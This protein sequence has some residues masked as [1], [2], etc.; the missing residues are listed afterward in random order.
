MNRTILKLKKLSRPSI[1][2]LAL[3]IIILSV[4]FTLPL[5]TQKYATVLMST[6]FMYVVL[7][8]SWTIFSGTTRYISL[9]SAAFFGMGVYT[10]AVLGK[11]L[12]LPAIIGIG[13]LLSFCLALIIG[14]LTLRLKGIYFAMFTLGLVELIVTLLRWW[15]VKFSNT[16]GRLVVYTDYTIVYYVMLV[17][18]LLLILTVHL[19]RR[20]KYGM[21]LQ[22]IGECEEAAAHIGINTTLLKV[23]TFAV[24]ALFI[25]ATGV[26]MATRW[27]YVD[28]RI[29]F[30]LQFSFMPVM[31]AMIGGMGQLYGPII[32]AVFFTYLEEF[33]I[34]RLPYH[35]MLIFGA[36]LVAAILYLPE[37]L[38]GLA[39]KCW[40]RGSG[41]KHAHT[42]S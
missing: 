1:S 32:G 27:T 26:I 6:I 40:K 21:A 31:M 36:I 15:E 30:N 34:T 24:S 10:A 11:S 28:P 13:S 2:R 8:V 4:L 7:T 19:I 29:A 17:I 35:Y 42:S 18:L 14:A 20:S 37:G 5:Y 41:G 16:V 3:M 39:Q 22:S 23:V 9:A 38:V 33:L 25:G 12:S